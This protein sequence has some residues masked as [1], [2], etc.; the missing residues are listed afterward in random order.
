MNRDKVMKVGRGYAPINTS[1]R[2][3]Q[4][5]IKTCYK[6]H[7]IANSRGLWLRAEDRGAIVKY[8][9]NDVVAYMTIS[10]EDVWIFG[11]EF[12][13]DRREL[14]ETFGCINYG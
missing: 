9:D 11:D 6:E 2:E 10:T 8:K 12:V 4:E 14:E 7:C 5:A 3:L 13:F 1:L